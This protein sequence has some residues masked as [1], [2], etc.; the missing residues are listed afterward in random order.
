MRA[1]S[2]AAIALA[3]TAKFST[4]LYRL[5]HNRLVDHYRRNAHGPKVSLDDDALEEPL[6]ERRDGPDAQ[7]ERRALAARL[8]GLV[9]ALPAAQREAF[10]LQHE[11]G[12]TVEEIAEATGVTRETAKS[13]LR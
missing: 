2:C 11:G 6:A 1:P 13:R 12:M 10:V 4:Y 3:P 7:C 9:E 8:L 5:A